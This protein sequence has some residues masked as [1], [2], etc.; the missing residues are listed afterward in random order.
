MP[1]TGTYGST[2][3]YTA[4]NP[5]VTI[6][7]ATGKVTVTNPA[8][9]GAGV[10]NITITATVKNGSATITK[11]FTVQVKELEPTTD[12]RKKLSMPQTML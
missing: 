11:E 3:T 8:F 2:I 7:N 5:A 6:D 9:T 1:V 10:Q 12:S 4:S